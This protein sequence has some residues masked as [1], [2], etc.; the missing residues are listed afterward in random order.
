MNAELASVIA[1]IFKPPIVKLMETIYNEIQGRVF[2]IIDE[3]IDVMSDMMPS[4][5][6]GFLTAFTVQQR[7]KAFYKFPNVPEFVIKQMMVEYEINKRLN[8]SVCIECES[9]LTQEE[10]G[11]RTGCCKYCLPWSRMRVGR[12]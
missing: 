8:Q 10:I 11:M 7:L 3:E 2:E 1:E 9:S 4:A 6:Y 12:T 5:S